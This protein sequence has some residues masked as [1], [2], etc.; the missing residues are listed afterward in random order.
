MVSSGQDLFRLPSRLPSRPAQR[1]IPEEM[2]MVLARLDSPG[3]RRTW[4]PFHMALKSP[5]FLFKFLQNP[6]YTYCVKLTVTGTYCAAL[7][8]I[9]QL[10][11]ETDWRKSSTCR[12]AFRNNADPDR[13]AREQSF[14]L[15]V[16][17]C[18]VIF[19]GSGQENNPHRRFGLLLDGALWDQHASTLRGK[20]QIVYT[21]ST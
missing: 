8:T 6:H 14:R 16:F 3:I 12:V 18:A 19:V 5:V 2:S 17:R 13:I 21:T 9:L 20:T 4:H 7:C 10:L 11:L 1:R 15:T